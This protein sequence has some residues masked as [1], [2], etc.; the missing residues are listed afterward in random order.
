MA[1]TS[2]FK[3][4]CPSCEAM[5][6]IRDPNLIGRKIDCPQCKYRFVVEDPGAG[7]E[8]EEELEEATATKRGG[9][10]AA[11][12][13][14]AGPRRRRGG[15]EDDDEEEERGRRPKPKS[16]GGSKGLVIGLVLG[17]VGLA[18]AGGVVAM[19]M[20]GGGEDSTPKQGGSNVAATQPRGRGSADEPGKEEGDAKEGEKKADKPVSAGGSSLTDVTVT[21]LLPNDSEQVVNVRVKDLL[22][23]PYGSAIVNPAGMIR[24][25]TSKQKLGFSVADVD[26]VLLATSFSQN[27]TFNIVRTT[28][29]VDVQAV[30]AALSLKPAPEGPIG[31]QDYY[32]MEPNAW[33]ENLAKQNPLAALQAGAVSGPK[34]GPTAVRF[35]DSQTLIFADLNVL[36]QFLT[37]KPTQQSKPAPAEAKGGEGEGGP[38]MG[39]PGGM[40]RGGPQPGMGGPGAMGRGGPQPGMGGPQPGMGGP[41][42]MMGRGGPG[43]PD[44]GPE[45]GEQTPAVSNAYLTIH[46]AMKTLLDRVEARGSLLSMA[47]DSSKAIQSLALGLTN[48]LPLSQTESTL[49]NTLVK[50]QAELVATLAASVQTKDGITVTGGLEY[51]TPEAARTQFTLL[52]K[53][54]P[55]LTKLLT[56]KTGLVFEQFDPENPGGAP[57][58]PGGMPLPGGMV[59]PGGMMPGGRGRAGGL[60]PDGGEGVAGPGGR[61]MPRGGGFGGPPGFGGPGAPGDQSSNEPPKPKS[62]IVPTLNEK[63]VVVVANFA[64]DSDAHESFMTGYVL[65]QVVKR[66][67]AMDM[68]AGN[69]SRA[70]DLAQAVVAYRDANKQLPRGTAD[71]PL[72]STRAGRPFPPNDRVSLFADLLP[73]L[74]QAELHSRIDPK[75]SWKDR[76]NLP[77]AMTLVPQLLDPTTP[78][79]SWWYRYPNLHTDVATTQFV[80]VAGVGLDAATLDPDDAAA[81]K[82]LGAFGYGRAIKLSDIKDKASETVLFL[83]V[84]PTVKRPWLAGGGATVQGVPETRSIQPFISATYN[85]KRGTMAVM[86]DGSVRFISENVSDDV[87]K[88]L[89]T[90][91]GS[92]EVRFSR[93]DAVVPVPENQAEL[94]TEPVA[95]VVPPPPPP[96]TEPTPPKAAPA[97]PRAGGGD[98]DGKV[99]SALTTNCAM[100]H[101]GPRSKGKVQIFTGPGALNPAAPKDKMAEAVAAGKMPPK[102]RPRPSP[103]DLGAMQGWLGGH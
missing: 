70:H 10:A 102:Q 26:R 63:T 45:G 21:N 5:V 65:P 60:T 99:L 58:I 37:T 89:C 3:Q 19:M 42:G 11:A 51:R 30:K 52:Q 68:A 57:G 39:G 64:L 97:A 54:T 96:K 75:R 49:V 29:P 6:P 43:G 61:G 69:P 72:P 36:K 78:S 16:S 66:K 95:P 92:D 38:Q 53:G 28:A 50:A 86:A 94:K 9:S 100:C 7:E 14:A 47:T 83:Q 87:F 35:Y 32:V 23:T 98:P 25:E 74:G 55:N 73:F 12:K 48:D 56:E 79:S 82:R 2:G 1:T 85:G 81:E 8:P 27:W 4:Q 90:V 77:A 44:G 15:D 46:P 20:M 34:S 24:P 67:G 71:R 17:V 41:G 33:L 101:T 93:D 59:G 88:A 40:G 18:I 103:E 22:K 13:K 62:S 84:P 80:G 91:R 76:E 31:G